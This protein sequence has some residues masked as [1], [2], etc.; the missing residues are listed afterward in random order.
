MLCDG[1]MCAASS[2]FDL[3]LP[4]VFVGVSRIARPPQMLFAAAI[5]A[6]H[7]LT[8]GQFWISISIAFPAAFAKE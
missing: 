4:P 8:I 7:A 6:F 5:V 2:I 3:T 1:R